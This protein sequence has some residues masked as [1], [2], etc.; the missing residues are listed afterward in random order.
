MVQSAA[1]WRRL[2]MVRGL[3]SPG[4][5]LGLP[6][7]RPQSGLPRVGLPDRQIELRASQIDFRADQFDFGVTQFDF[8]VN[9]FDFGIKHR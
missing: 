9:E 3:F 7:C 2:P 4:F 5:R 1:G 8:R 6:C